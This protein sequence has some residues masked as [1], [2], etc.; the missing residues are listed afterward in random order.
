MGQVHCGICDSGLLVWKQNNWSFF[1]YLI[2]I[3]LF[4]IKHIMT[5]T[6]LT[7][8]NAHFSRVTKA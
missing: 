2:F 1:C 5:N 6:E 7:K 3:L 4:I 8:Q